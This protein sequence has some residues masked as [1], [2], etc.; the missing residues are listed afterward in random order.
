MPRGSQE[1]ISVDHGT[2]NIVEDDG[3]FMQKQIE[4]DFVT[5]QY[6]VIDPAT[7]ATVLM[8]PVTGFPI[9]DPVV[10]PVPLEVTQRCFQFDKYS[11]AFWIDPNTD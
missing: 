9:V 6:F 3:T 10:G 2:L 11:N 8:N 7:D 4:T 5:G 1:K